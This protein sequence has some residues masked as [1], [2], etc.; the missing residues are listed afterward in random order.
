MSRI[1]ESQILGGLQALYGDV[2]FSPNA[3]T[4]VT[5]SD[6]GNAIGWMPGGSLFVLQKLNQNLN[7]GFF[8]LNLKRTY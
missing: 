1:E 5:G 7:H 4:T 2:E 8:A 6:G 3:A